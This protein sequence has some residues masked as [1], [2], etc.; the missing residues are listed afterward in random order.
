MV[1]LPI[2]QTKPVRPKPPH[3]AAGI[4]PAVGI[5]P[6]VPQADGRVGHDL[7][8]ALAGPLAKGKILREVPVAISSSRISGAK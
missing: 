1:S 7:V 6:D 4:F 5:V 2:R 3:A 8:A